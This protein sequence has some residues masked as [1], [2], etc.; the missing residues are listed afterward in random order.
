[1]QSVRLGQSRRYRFV[2]F[3]YGRFSY[4][5]GLMLQDLISAQ[6][7]SDYT[8]VELPGSINDLQGT[9]RVRTATRMK[10]YLAGLSLTS[11]LLMPYKELLCFQ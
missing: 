11:Q 10:R 3:V 5:Q 6:L 8:I 7:I 4:F 2:L 1:M 9:R